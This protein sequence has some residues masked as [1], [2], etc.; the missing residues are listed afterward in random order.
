MAAALLP[1]AQELGVAKWIVVAVLGIGSAAEAARALASRRLS[2][3]EESAAAETVRATTESSLRAEALSCLALEPVPFKDVSIFDDLRVSWSA[4]ASRASDGQMPYVPRSVDQELHEALAAH[5]FIVVAGPSKSGKSR[6]AAELA[7]ADMPDAA[8]FVPV[9]PSRSPQALA[10]LSE[11]G[12]AL[13]KPGV[14]ALIWLDDVEVYLRSGA[15]T[16]QTLRAFRAWGHPL[17]IIATIRERELAAFVDPATPSRGEAES[18]EEAR[19]LLERAHT[20]RLPARL[21]ADELSVARATYPSLNLD[22]ELG[23]HLISGPRLI[24]KL[25][26]GEEACPEGVAVARAIV[27]WKRA[28]VL[29]GLSR[30]ALREL[31]VPYLLALRP[32]VAVTQDDLETGIEWAC[33]EVAPSIALAFSSA[34]GEAFTPFDYVVGFFDGETAAGEG[35][36]DISEATWR[37]VLNGVSADEATSVGWS[38]SDRGRF[39]LAQDAFEKAK[40]AA[41]P[42]VADRAEVELGHVYRELK[43][44]AQARSH[45]ELATACNTE[46]VQAAGF[47]SLALMV[48]HDDDVAAEHLYRQAIAAAP[49]SSSAA[50]SSVNLGLILRR[51]AVGGRRGPRGGGVILR[52]PRADLSSE[53]RALEDEA[54][55]LFELAVSSDIPDAQANGAN[56]LGVLLGAYGDDDAAVE[57]FKLGVTHG[58]R[59][60]CVNMARILVR[61]KDFE[62][63]ES[64]LGRLTASAEPW[65]V[66]RG[67]IALSLLEFARGQPGEAE[68]RLREAAGLETGAESAE[69]RLR[70]ASLLR[71]RPDSHDEVV[72]LLTQV[73]QDDPEFSAADAAHRLGHLATDHGEAVMWWERAVEAGHEESAS[74][75]A[76]SIARS[77]GT[78]GDDAGAERMF[79]QVLAQWPNSDAAAKSAVNLALLL[80]SRLPHASSSSKGVQFGTPGDADDFTRSI[81]Q[82]AERLLMIAVSSM[83]LEARRNGG[84][85]LGVLLKDEGRVAEAESALRQAAVAGSEQA[86]VNL[87]ALLIDEDRFTEARAEADELLKR[88]ISKEHRDRILTMLSDHG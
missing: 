15:L 73:W 26:S 53:A 57:A 55:V 27:D 16:S 8:L 86:S 46:H 34:D 33:A 45:Y 31:F 81:N 20:V 7:R 36:R 32:R 65:V 40:H 54:R 19:E 52:M 35:A 44:D 71:D 18:A 1:M 83:D 24:Q 47:Y 77:L 61:R 56:S 60:S 69:A 88:D 30:E 28:G 9:R 6:T 11:V 17:K 84:N 76:F 3:K 58:D 79:K 87:M 13:I 41:D 51:R 64:L 21:G 74:Q 67:K 80:R 78:R 50:R 10:R 4:L 29:G 72:A 22:D 48:G 38:A 62:Q 37:T 59:N 85:A 5:D 43:D 82:D 12:T 70:L 2:R 23:V 49:E 68:A 39:D 25:S 42:E 75:A 14:P 63:A 66:A